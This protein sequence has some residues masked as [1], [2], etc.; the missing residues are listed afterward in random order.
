MYDKIEENRIIF[1]SEDIF[2]K[3][4]LRHNDRHTNTVTIQLK[5]VEKYSFNS[6]AL[7]IPYGW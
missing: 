2:E 1:K 4:K 7:H 5:N 6:E 3:R